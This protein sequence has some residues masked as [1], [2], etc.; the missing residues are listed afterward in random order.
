[1]DCSRSKTA[2]YCSRKCC[3]KISDK[4]YYEKNRLTLN[5]MMRKNHRKRADKFISTYKKGKGCSLCWYNKHYEILHFHH[6]DPS[7]KSFEITL[8]KIAKKTQEEMKKVLELSSE[9]RLQTLRKALQIEEY[10]IAAENTALGVKWLKK[11][12]FIYNRPD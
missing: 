6:K 4:K 7:E 12:I 2:I 1:M 9:E 5:Q 3:K 10:K 11:A 8:F